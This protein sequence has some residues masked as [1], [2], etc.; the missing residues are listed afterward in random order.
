[1]PPSAHDTPSPEQQRLI[2]G[3]SRA[4]QAAAD[5]SSRISAGLLLCELLGNAGLYDQALPLLEGLQ[6][7][8]LDDESQARVLRR[9]GW[10]YMRQSRFDQAA[11]C[12]GEAIIKLSQCG[13][14]L[15][16]FHV[17]RDLAWIYYRQGFLDQA[18]NYGDGAHLILSNHAGSGPAVDEAWELLDHVLA[19]IEAAAGDHGAAIAWL[20]RERAIIERCGDTA[21]LAALYNKLASVHQARGDLVTALE[22]QQRAQQAAVQHGDLLRTAVCYKNLAEIHYCMGDLE[23]SRQFNDRFMEL[24]QSLG[25]SL[26]D[27]FGHAGRARLQAELG[28]HTAAEQSYKQA[29]AVA[30]AIKFKGREAAILAELAELY[31]R[32]NKLQA[33]D[34]CF[35]QSCETAVEINITGS[36]RQ[37]VLKAQLLCAR[38]EAALA[39]ER[40]TALL[41]DAAR[42]LGTA[43]ARPIAIDDEEIMSAPELEMAAHAL[44]A[45]VQQLQ[46]RR[47][48]AIESLDRARAARDRLSA[49]FEGAVRQL[50]LGRRPFREL[51]ALEKTIAMM[52]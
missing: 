15:E 19:L 12:L 28:D 35:R 27:A 4:Y 16:I 5:P 24:N 51:A 33:A 1:M 17:Y 2:D 22:L 48:K 8:A 6:Q 21:K 42:A 36:Q 10:L 18:R 39:V 20:E 40:R 52:P 44:L 37:M 43:L 11:T 3:A 9:T 25:N 31:C 45:R 46:G 41:Q 34:D 7:L 29:L 13:G 49:Q 30:R 23:R 38:A 50:F 47:D 14:S 32:G 26:G